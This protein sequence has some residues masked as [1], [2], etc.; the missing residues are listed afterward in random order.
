M[1]AKG[2]SQEKRVLGSS[3]SNGG[4][5][6][7]QGREIQWPKLPVMEDANGIL[8]ISKG[9][10]TSVGQ[11]IKAVDEHEGQRMGVS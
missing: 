4:R 10:F 1:R 6:K 2:N 8:S 3:G 9:S 5:W 7:V 11:K